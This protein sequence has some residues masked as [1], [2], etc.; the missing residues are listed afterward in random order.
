M[1]NHTFVRFCCWKCRQS[2]VL[3]EAMKLAIRVIQQ[4][5]IGA[6]FTGH[7]VAFPPETRA[8]AENKPRP[9]STACPLPAHSPISLLSCTDDTLAKA[10]NM[11]RRNIMF[12]TH[13]R[14]QNVI[15][16]AC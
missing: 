5:K 1:L 15:S 10:C 16:C 13:Q 9:S 8:C 6:M 11:G 12:H 2:S 14:P 7:R 4:E 3:V